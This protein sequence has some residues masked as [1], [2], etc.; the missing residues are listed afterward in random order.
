MIIQRKSACLVEKLS[1]FLL[2]C[3]PTKRKIN[4][5]LGPWDFYWLHVQA[6]NPQEISIWSHLTLTLLQTSPTM[7]LLGFK[8]KEWIPDRG[9]QTPCTGQ[10]QCPHSITVNAGIQSYFYH[11]DSWKRI[12]TVCPIWGKIKFYISDLTF[13]F[14]SNNPLRGLWCGIAATVELLH[15]SINMF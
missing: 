2:P 10:V 9:C 15:L 14:W 11:T 6:T 3:R 1:S 7:R 8:H 4:I 13:T 12:P 5:Y